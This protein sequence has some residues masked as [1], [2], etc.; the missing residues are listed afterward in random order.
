MKSFCPQSSLPERQNPP[1]LDFDAPSE[2]HVV[3]MITTFVIAMI[4]TFVIVLIIKVIV[5]ADVLFRSGT[6]V[7]VSVA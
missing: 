1:G 7:I 6:L 2:N 4:I 5:I 3:N